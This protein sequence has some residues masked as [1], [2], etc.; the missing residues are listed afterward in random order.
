M[1]PASKYFSFCPIG[2]TVIGTLRFWVSASCREIG[3]SRMVLT[4]STTWSP[5][6]LYSP[7]FFSPASNIV[8]VPSFFSVSERRETS[9]TTWGSVPGSGVSLRWPSHVPTYGNVCADPQPHPKPRIAATAIIMRQMALFTPEV[10]TAMGLNEGEYALILKLLGREPSTTELGMFAVMWSEH[11]GYKY[12]RPVLAAFKRYKEALEGDG[13]ETAG[14]VELGDGF[15]VTL[16][17]ESHNHP[18]AV[19]PYQGAAT[20]V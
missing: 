2:V 10:Y 4:L 18:S 20:G 9:S 14:I 3:R 13:S 12:S 16:K 7:S 15:G 6:K 1:P 17:V 5:S 19:E 11:C 8:N